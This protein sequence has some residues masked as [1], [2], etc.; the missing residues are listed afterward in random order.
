VASIKNNNIWKKTYLDLNSI[1]RIQKQSK[2][3]KITSYFELIYIHAGRGTFTINK[4]EKQFASHQLLLIPPGSTYKLTSACDVDYYLVSFQVFIKDKKE[5]AQ[6]S[7]AGLA[8]IQQQVIPFHQVIAGLIEDLYRLKGEEISYIHFLQRAKLNEI[9]FHLLSYKKHVTPNDTLLAIEETKRYMDTHFNEKLKIETLAQQAE[10]SPK[11]YSEMFKKQYGIT[12][13]DYITRLRVNKAKQLLLLTKDSI[14]LI[15][16]SVGY[17]DEFYLSRKFK[18]AVGISPSAYREKRNQKIASYDFATTGHLLALQILPYAAPIHPKWT[19]DY[20]EQFKDDI[21]FHLESYR[22]H[23]EWRKNIVRLQ[24][25]KPHLIIAKQDITAEE[26]AELVKIAPVFYYS[27]TANWKD[28]F[29]HIADYLNRTKEAKEWMEHY[30]THAKRASAQLA[31]YLNGKKG[32]VISLFQD[33]FYLN[34]SR[35]A[36]EVIFE[37][38]Q[39]ASSQARNQWKHNEGTQLDKIIKWQPDFILLNIR[40]DEETLKYWQKLRKSSEWN[41]IEAVKRQQVYF[42]QSDPW[43]ECSASSHIRVIDNLVELITEKVQGKERK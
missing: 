16:S 7:L 25:A 20:Y 2:E 14:R 38:L 39:I 27:E 42:I 12:V 21:I 43:N 5:E 10:L 32:L 26:K 3:N 41:N 34:R 13:S 24:E 40:Q 8:C 36:I 30:E 19:L 31:P 22:K 33:N 6:P 11:Y 29:S 37:E 17:A 35:T 23:T 18:Q 4:E 15:A 1:N 28:Q 9:F